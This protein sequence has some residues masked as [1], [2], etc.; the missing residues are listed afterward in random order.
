MFSGRCG[1]CK[2]QLQTRK[3]IVGFK[4]PDWGIGPIYEGTEEYCSYCEW[5]G[6]AGPAVLLKKIARESQNE[7]K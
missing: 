1:K 7:S 3:K 5:K 2:N 6:D 4:N